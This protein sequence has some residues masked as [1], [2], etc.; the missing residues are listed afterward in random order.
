[1]VGAI[2][3]DYSSSIGCDNP[4]RG[5]P[6]P[7]CWRGFNHGIPHLLEGSLSTCQSIEQSQLFRVSLQMLPSFWGHRSSLMHQI[8]EIGSGTPMWVASAYQWHPAMSWQKEVESGFIR[9]P[10]GVGSDHHPH[11]RV[12]FMVMHTTI[13]CVQRKPF[14]PDGATF[15]VSGVAGRK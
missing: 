2:V 11:W 13:C 8:S 1:M 12:S 3:V 6:C 10:V 14:Q 4:F 15:S 5:Q 9:R 7:P